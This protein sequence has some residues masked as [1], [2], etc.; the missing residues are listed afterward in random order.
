M[1]RTSF[2]FCGLLAALALAGCTDVIN[3]DLPAGQPVLSVDGAITDGPG[4]YVVNLTRTAPYLEGRPLPRVTGAV[5][6]LADN[7]GQADTLRERSP[8]VYV[9]RRLR[10]KIG[11]QY[12]LTIQAE[13]QTYRAQTEIRRALT[14]DSL[15]TKYIA[16]TTPLDSAG[17]EVT[18]H[19]Q[20]L[21]GPGDYLRFKVYRNGRLWNQPA[22]LFVSSDQLVDGNYLNFN[23]NTH[24][25]K[26][27]DRVRVEINSLTEDYYN[28]LNELATQTVNF[29]IFAA[30]PANVRTNLHNT[31]G[32]S[33]KTAVGYFAGYSVRADSLLIN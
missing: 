23:F 21:P 2:L 4:P 6:T 27:G 24:S 9:T 16:E 29:G 17:Y 30:P 32:S 14:I 33:G 18:F 7:Q 15:G 1:L 11:N 10:G 25:Y 13:G 5:L 20:E 28:F 8:G 3:L 31:L 12:V 26:K 19:G 22:D